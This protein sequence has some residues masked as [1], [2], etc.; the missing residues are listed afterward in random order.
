[1]R[2]MCFKCYN[3]HSLRTEFYVY[4]LCYYEL[5]RY[6]IMLIVA[7]DLSELHDVIHWYNVYLRQMTAVCSSPQATWITGSFLMKKW[8]GLFSAN[9]LLPN[10]KTAP[11]SA[12]KDVLKLIPFSV[13]NFTIS[14]NHILLDFSLFLYKTIITCIQN[15]ISGGANLV[16]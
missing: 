2:K 15:L 16:H 8:L 5:W 7:E 9:L 1:M 3:N 14:C 10:V 13:Y 4:V 6:E 11:D 12:T